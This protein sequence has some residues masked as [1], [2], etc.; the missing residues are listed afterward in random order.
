M[1]QAQT[2]FSHKFY[3]YGIMGVIHRIREW[4]YE[5]HNVFQKINSPRTA[6]VY[7]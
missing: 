3:S 2:M 5:L 1:T 6:K 4:S 7:I